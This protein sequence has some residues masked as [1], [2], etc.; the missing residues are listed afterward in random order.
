MF[1]LLQMHRQDVA[2]VLVR[3]ECY[4]RIRGFWSGNLLHNHFC[5]IAN[6]ENVVK[7]TCKIVTSS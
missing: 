3:L 5:C 1:I 2:M 4:A 6:F 7:L